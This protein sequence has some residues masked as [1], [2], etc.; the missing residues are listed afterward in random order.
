MDVLR[1]TT[2]FSYEGIPQRLEVHDQVWLST[3]NLS[4]E[5]LNGMRKLHPKVCEPFKITENVKQATF[6]LELSEPM[7][8]RGFH[9]VFDCSLVKTFI[10]DE[11]GRY[12]EELT[13]VRLTDGGEECE[14]RSIIGSKKI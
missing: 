12:D 11:Y 1:N 10:P 9:D 2:K 13:A 8:I 6:R 14:V 5:Y 7:K 3:K 4:I